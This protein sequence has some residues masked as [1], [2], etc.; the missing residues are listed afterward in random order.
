MKKIEKNPIIDDQEERR[1][2]VHTRWTLGT[3]WD[4]E[5]DGIPFEVTSLNEGDFKVRELRIKGLSNWVY[6]FQMKVVGGWIFLTRNEMV[7]LMEDYK[8][9]TETETK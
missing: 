1:T 9:L 6:P 2:S 8:L 5:E 7:K 3:N 4:C